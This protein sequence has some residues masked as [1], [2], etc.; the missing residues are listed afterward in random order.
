MVR[1]GWV[2]R[3]ALS[4]Q[5]LFNR[6]R[7]DRWQLG[8]R[9]LSRKYGVHRRLVRDAPASPVAQPRKRPVRISPRMEPYKKT[10][11]EWLRAASR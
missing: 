10:V 8:L 6:I 4:K 11:D 5:E 2:L 7:R 1:R 9:A 3:L